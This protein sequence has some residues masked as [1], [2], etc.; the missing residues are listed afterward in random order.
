M[1]KTSLSNARGVGSIPS[2][3]VK[4]SLAENQNR[5][6]TVTN[7]IKTFKMVHIF[8]NLKK[9][10]SVK[11]GQTWDQMLVLQLISYAT[12]NRMVKLSERQLYPEQVSTV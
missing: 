7:S 2:Q 6:N 5:Y 9:K 1:V 12:L 8:K 10:K 4:L 11:G 3:G